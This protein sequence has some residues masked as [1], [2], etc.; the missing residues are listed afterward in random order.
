MLLV[1][2]PIYRRDGANSDLRYNAWY[3]RWA[4]DSYRALLTEAAAVNGWAL[5]D[6]WD[7]VDGNQFTDSPVHMTPGATRATA[8]RIAA[9]FQSFPEQ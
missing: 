6:L 8:E 3:P 5:L 4:Y 9:W 1:N 7:T 2:E